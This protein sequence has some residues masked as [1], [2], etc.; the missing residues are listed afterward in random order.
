MQYGENV[1]QDFQINRRSKDREWLVRK[2]KSL[3]L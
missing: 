2:Y 3:I 1:L